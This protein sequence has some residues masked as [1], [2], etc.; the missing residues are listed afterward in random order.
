MQNNYR[1]DGLINYPRT[2]MRFDFYHIA[3]VKGRRH[4]I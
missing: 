2:L 3:A 1:T 4:C